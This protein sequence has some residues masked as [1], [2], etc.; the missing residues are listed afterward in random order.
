MRSGS[1]A[2][3]ADWFSP[4]GETRARP[5]HLRRPRRS[6]WAAGASSPL[7]GER[8][9]S[10]GAGFTSAYRIPELR[11]AYSMH[12][13]HKTTMPTYLLRVDE[14]KANVTAQGF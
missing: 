7:I 9:S 8:A 1:A 11:K 13:T 14:K 12:E 4:S 3:A 2:R 10:A 6:G 5:R